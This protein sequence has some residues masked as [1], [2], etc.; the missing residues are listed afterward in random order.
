MFLA[1]NHSFTEA[2]LNA[3]RVTSFSLIRSRIEHV[4][5]RLVALV[6]ILLRGEFA[7]QKQY[8]AAILDVLICSR[9]SDKATLCHWPVPPLPT[10]LP[11]SQPSLFLVLLSPPSSLLTPPLFPFLA[12]PSVSFDNF[13]YG[14][15]VAALL[16]KA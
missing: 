2:F 7:G 10:H 1:Q 12:P 6:S 4:P 11:F 14:V 3:S 16:K 9:S 8:P 13:F 15:E 5:S